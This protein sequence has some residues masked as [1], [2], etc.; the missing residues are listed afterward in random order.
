MNSQ[1]RILKSYS[2]E[3][4]RLRKFL[5]ELSLT[6]LIG[7]LNEGPL[8]ESL[9][10]L[11]AEPD[12]CVEEPVGRYIADIRRKNHVIEIQTGGFGPIRNKLRNLLEEYR[13]TLV[14]PIACERWIV[15]QPKTKRDKS[16]RRK[17]PKHATVEYVFEKLVSIP[18]L[19]AHPNFDL[20]VVAIEEEQIRRYDAKRAWRKRGWVTVERR[21]VSV[22]G[23]RVFQTPDD[24]AA[25]I[26]GLTSG[27]LP[28]PFT[29]ADM[30]E[31]AGIS[32]S[33]AQQAAY[34]LRSVD[35]IMKTGKNGNSILYS[36]TD[37]A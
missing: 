29:T 35:V 30:A 36:K 22:L 26:P 16:T 33:L 10:Q 20:E 21:L 18:D 27:A 24:L 1:L 3:Y 5:K 17:S 12:D 4:R 31:S 2:W 32:R 8:H 19:I 9:K 11:Y 34:C 23:R 14:T 15:K 7:G 37:A 28:D 25:L 6:T 13:V